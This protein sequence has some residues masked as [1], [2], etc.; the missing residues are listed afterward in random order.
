MKRQ[1]TVLLTADEVAVRLGE[2]IKTV[3]KHTRRGDYKAFAINLGAENR[4][5][6]RYDE[7]LLE[8]WIDAKRAA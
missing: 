4:P 5:R 2:H 6:W 1:P 3:R 8:R 7:A